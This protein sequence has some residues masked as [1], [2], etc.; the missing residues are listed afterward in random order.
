[1][2]NNNMKTIKFLKENKINLNGIIISHTL[3]VIY[4]IA[5]VKMYSSGL[6]IKVSLI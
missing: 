4:Q 1:M 5:L 2:D 6:I 3:Y